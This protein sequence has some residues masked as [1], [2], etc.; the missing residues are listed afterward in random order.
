M[1]TASVRAS[2]LGK[3]PWQNEF[4]RTSGLCPELWAFDE[5]LFRNAEALGECTEGASYAFLVHTAG[6]AAASASI[7]GVLRPS[8]DQAGREFPL[9]VACTVGLASDIVRHPEVI[10]LVLEP[11]WNLALEVL[12][13]VQSARLPSDDSRL[14]QLAEQSL[15]EGA[16]AT[17]LYST[18]VK[19][20]SSVDFCALLGRPAEWL[21]PALQGI[22]DRLKPGAGR[23]RAV[24]VPLGNAGGGALCFWLD[25]IRRAMHWHDHTPSFFWSHDEEGGEALVFAG[26]PDDATLASVWRPTAS[27]AVYDANNA[28][29]PASPALGPWLAGAAEGSVAAALDGV[30]AAAFG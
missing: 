25:V 10:P 12:A 18:W 13:D 15:G 28:D 8:Q 19:A 11:Q 20:T 14:A 1:S 2:V 24:R 5:W 26:D 16:S 9:A 3:A 7:A 27:S 30:D 6:T 4:L 17:D 23:I 21:G 22:V 29:S